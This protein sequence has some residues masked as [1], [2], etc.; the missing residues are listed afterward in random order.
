MSDREDE[1]KEIIDKLFRKGL[2]EKL[3]PKSLNR[4]IGDLIILKPFPLKNETNSGLLFS[5]KKGS[6]VRRG[7]ILKVSETISKKIGLKEGMIVI[8]ESHSGRELEID[9]KKL[10]ALKADLAIMEDLRP[11]SEKELEKIIN[12]I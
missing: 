11:I 5:T 8:Y 2:L 4:S 12:S 9:G 10:L 1:N 3:T 7:M 6:D